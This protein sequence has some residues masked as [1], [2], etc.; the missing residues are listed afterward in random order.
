[1]TE[2]FRRFAVTDPFSR[3]WQVEF[4]WLQNAISIRHADA[5]DCKYFLSCGG[6]EREIVIALPHPLLTALARELGRELTDSW[7]LRLAGLHLRQMI[8]TWEDMERG[9]VTLSAEDLAG[10]NERID[11]GAAEARRVSRLMH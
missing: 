7:C 1:M 2:D 8:T 4:R 11:A 6:E 3:E 9:I 5:V 10:H